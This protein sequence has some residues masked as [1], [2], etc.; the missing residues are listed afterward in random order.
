MKNEN[1]NLGLTALMLEVGIVIAICLIILARLPKSD[2]WKEV[3]SPTVTP[4]ISAIPTATPT[5]FPTVTPTAMLTEEQTTYRTFFP[6]TCTIK[7]EEPG[8]IG[9]CADDSLGHMG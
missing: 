1:E 8:H 3:P 5:A 7:E 9:R 6:K 4:T 2:G